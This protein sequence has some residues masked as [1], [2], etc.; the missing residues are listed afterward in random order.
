MPVIG[1]K[2]DNPPPEPG[3]NKKYQKSGGEMQAE[4]NRREQDRE[5]QQ[6]ADNFAEDYEVGKKDDGETRR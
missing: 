4:R 6:D 2:K 1:G 5:G 3:E